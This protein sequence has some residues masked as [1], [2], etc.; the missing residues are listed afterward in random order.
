MLKYFEFG[1][2]DIEVPVILK[3]KNSFVIIRYI[4]KR[5]L[6][7]LFFIY[8]TF[9]AAVATPF[10]KPHSIFIYVIGFSISA[11]ILI[12]FFGFLYMYLKFSNAELTFSKDTIKI[13]SEH[14]LYLI[15][16]NSI[17]FIE[18][19]LFSNLVIHTNERKLSFP[20][21][22]LD[23]KSKELLFNYLIDMTPGRSE[24]FEKVWEFFDAIVMA[25]ILAIHIIQYIIQN[26]YIPSGSMENTLLINDHLFAEKL[27]YGPSI[28][29][30]YGMNSSA[31]LKFLQIRDI[32]KGDVIIFRPPAPADEDKEYI[33][34]CIAVEG[35]EF[36]IKN[37]GVY[38]NGKLVDEPY[39]K[40]V[41]NYDNFSSRDLIEGIVPEGMVIAMGDNRQNSQD[42]RFFGYLEK[43]RIKARALILYF[44][45]D[46]IKNLDFSRFGLIK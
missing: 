46:Q 3:L 22:F 35:D 21:E 41:T 1:Y 17:E 40:G 31:H 39:V 25:F 44:N 13:R 5:F 15:P 11:A 43:K 30:M 28:P 12:R 37:N 14:L 4:I 32:E 6:M 38:V 34:R 9:F 26:Y 8:A 18:Y 45:W 24:V 20:V 29:Q 23:E 7:F 33:K 27:T 2:F 36:H 42:S 19:N 10:V 16:V